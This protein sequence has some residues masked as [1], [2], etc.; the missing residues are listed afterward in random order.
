MPLLHSAAVQLVAAADGTGIAYEVSGSGPPIVL[1]HGITEDH[2]AWAPVVDRLRPDFTCIALDARGHGESD[3]AAIDYEPLTFAGDIATVV[4]A[5][6]L[7]GPP[8]LVGHSLGGFHASVYAAA[9]LGPVRG[10]VNVDQTLRMSDFATH[11]R[12]AEERLRGADF[13]DTMIELGEALGVDRLTRESRNELHR[14][15]TRARPEVVLAIWQ[16]CFEVDGPEIDAMIEQLVL[17]NLRVPYLAIYG[18]DPGTGYIDWLT[19]RVPSASVEVWEGDGHWLHL[20]D[21]DRFAARVRK[22]VATF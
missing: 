4:D 3:V 21:P 12:P 22:F 19:A 14:Y 10:V 20:V 8:V 16:A 5:V 2:H 17:A 15:R 18:S 13:V 9:G 1:L 7:S 6:E 11:V